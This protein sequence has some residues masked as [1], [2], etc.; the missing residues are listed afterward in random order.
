MRASQRRS[1]TFLLLLIAFPVAAHH[2]M[3][4]L[5]DFK[6]RFTRSG[7]VTK[8]EWTNP[9]IYLFVNAQ[10]DDGQMESWAFEGP[11]PVY[12]R[13]RDDV[14]KSDF[15]NAVGKSVTVDAS[16]ARNGS[17]SGLIRMVTLPDG[18]VVPLCPDNC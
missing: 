16:R 2:S 6:Q 7:T 10:G 15:Q 4:G 8:L 5:F 3:L 9:H 12:F 1:L 18:K 11:S 13:R 17:R 14:S